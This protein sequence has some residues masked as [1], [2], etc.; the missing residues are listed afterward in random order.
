MASKTSMLS[1]RALKN[2]DCD[3]WYLRRVKKDAARDL[4]DLSERA[5]VENCYRATRAYRF[6]SL[7]EGFSLTNISS[8]GADVT[9]TTNIFPGLDA[10]VIKNR[11]RSLCQTFVAK[12]FANDSPLPQFTTKGGDFD[13]VN[14]AEDLDQTICAEFAEPQGQFNDMAEMHRHGALI[15]TASTG[16]YAIF[17][18]DYD[19]A[20]RP[21]A[22]LDDTLTLGIYR[23]YRYGPL[24][25]CVRTVWMLPEEAV[26]KFGDKFKQQIYDNVEPRA[27]A[28]IAGKGVG[29]AADTV[30]TSHHVLQRREVRIIMG[31]AVQ[32]GSGPDAEV[33]RQMF[34]L[35]DQTVLRDKPYTKHLPPMVKWEYDIELGGDWGTPLTQSVYMLSRYQNRILNDVDAAERKTSQVIIAVQSGTAGAKA[36]QAQLGQANAVQLVQVDGPVES[37]FKIFDSPKFSRDSLALEAV[38][39]Q[40]QFDDTRIGRNH[41]TGTKPQGTT[42]GVQESLAASYYTESFADAERRSIQVRAVGTTKIFLWVLQALS[43][44]GFERWIGDKDFRRQVRAADL[45]LDDDKYILEI[46]PV[47]EGKDTPK[48]RLEKAERWLKDPSVPFIGAD[49]VRMSQ[50]YDLDRMK[51]QVYAL[52]GWVEDQVKR[53]LKSPAPV[54]AQRDFYQPPER[55]MQLEG[56]RSALRIMA[57]AFLRARQSKAP[58]QRLAWFEKFCNDCVTLIESEEKRIATLSQPPAPPGGGAPL[59]PPGPPVSEQPMPMA[60]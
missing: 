49:M 4:L 3:C 29:Q 57:N 20:S 7:F 59:A 18:I 44:K 27:G 58:P 56:I 42:S 41:A 32:V 25:H 19:N 34:I 1:D 28:F 14:G 30:S 53:Y 55:W 54:M 52:D 48:S 10:P 8:W 12:S 50:N 47:G 51:D 39:D 45:D 17:C 24:R 13:Q 40:A 38:Y 31:W 36:L 5:M 9:S 35:K 43:K 2:T 21:E 23:A 16:Q 26:R 6:A 22:E 11:C 15:A 33:G 60:A 46:K 37:A